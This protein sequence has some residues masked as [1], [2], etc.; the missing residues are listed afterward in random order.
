MYLALVPNLL[1]PNVDVRHLKEMLYHRVM[2]NIFQFGQRHQH[3]AC[4]AR[5][6]GLVDITEFRVQQDRDDV[7]VAMGHSVMHCGIALE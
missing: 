2:G 3:H 5:V 7:E 1:R 4:V 6:V